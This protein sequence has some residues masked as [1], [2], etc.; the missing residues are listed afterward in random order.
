MLYAIL[1]SSR[2]SRFIA[3]QGGVAIFYYV[4]IEKLLE[5]DTLKY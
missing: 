2:E 4:S 1:G 5:H 3:V